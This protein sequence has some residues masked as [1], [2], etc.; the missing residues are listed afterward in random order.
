MTKRP[1]VFSLIKDQSIFMTA[2]MALLTFLSVIALGIALSIG[3]G[4]I[5]WNAQWDLFATVQVMKSDNNQ[6]V[7]KIIK[8]NKEKISSVKEISSDQM[9]D[10]MR[11][12]LSG[13]GTALENYL[14]KM[15]ELEF[16]DNKDLEKIGEQIS[17]HARFLTHADALKHSTS[18]GWKM[19]LISSFVLILTL[20]AIAICISYIARNIALL[21]RRELEILN[22]IGARDSFITRQMQIII[23]KICSVAA[24]AGFLVAVPVL[25]LILSAA[26]SA[27]VGLMAMLGINGFGWLLLFLLPI[28]IIIFSIWITKRTTINIL[29]NS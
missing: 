10:L 6:A 16:K 15:Y 4:V 14:P 24:S 13:G 1:I 7:Q 21:H 8:D 17:K 27:R 26:H 20:G 18:A 28:C 19:I 22:Q 5:R 25:L 23:F 29:K 11:P 9:K 12:W 2:I 3:T